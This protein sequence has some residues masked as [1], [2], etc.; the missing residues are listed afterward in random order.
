MTALREAAPTF[1]QAADVL[2][3][4]AQGGGQGPSI[5][6]VL[7]RPSEDEA[8]VG[9]GATRV[10]RYACGELSVS[11]PEGP[12]ERR[13]CGERDLFAALRGALL[14]GVPAFFVSSLDL[15]RPARDP[16]LPLFVLVQ[17][18]AEVRVGGGRPAEPRA[19]GGAGAEA[20]CRAAIERAGAEGGRAPPAAPAGDRPFCRDEAAAYLRGW[21]GDSDEAFLARV[22]RVRAALEGRDTKA[23]PIRHHRRSFGAAGPPDALGLYELYA[24]S[25]PACVASHY[26]RLGALHSV[27]CSPENVFELAGGELSL[28]VVSGT[29]PRSDDEARDG[30]LA[31]EL[32][33]SIKE[34][35][36]HLLA[37]EQSLKKAPGF[38]APETVAVPSRFEI[39]QLARVRHLH[40]R[41]TGR[42][43]PGLDW[44]DV[45]ERYYPS[46]DAYDAD[47]K[48]VADAMT[49]P[50]RFYG[51]VVGHLSEDGAR[52][53]CYQ[54]LRSCLLLGGEMHVAVGVGVTR[55]S[56]PEAEVGES[57]TKL[58]GLLGAVAAWE[59]RAARAQP[60]PS[61]SE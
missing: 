1:R 9:L 7:H 28:D 34:L 41:V 35:R 22:R 33:A 5:G 54:N 27:G 61:G 29:G 16:G 25:E 39:K 50:H 56:E 43:R 18:A 31:A 17:P 32:T 57:H 46:L 60:E 40:S 12:V 15:H 55:L 49:Q 4:L 47:L 20:L 8:V 10:V 51:G 58:T 37:V 3:S 44:L 59:R 38:C 6:Y 23:F 45:L 14:P 48:G 53:R 13:R 42:L 19:F 11:G 36:E 30:R 26:F 52:A 24:A 21:E 2:R